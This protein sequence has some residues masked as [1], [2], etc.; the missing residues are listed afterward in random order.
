MVRLNSGD[1]ESVKN[2]FIAITSRS[3]PTRMV[4]PVRILMIGQ[5]D[6]LKIIRIR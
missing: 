3:T 6:L 1:L 5:I 4:A 2:L